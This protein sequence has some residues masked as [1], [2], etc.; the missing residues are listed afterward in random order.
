M[1]PF[2]AVVIR[3]C[4]AVIDRL[5]RSVAVPCMGALMALLSAA[6]LRWWFDARIS[7]TFKGFDAFSPFPSR[8][9]RRT[10][11]FG[12]R[13]SNPERRRISN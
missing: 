5:I 9:Y 4:M 12:S 10:G 2:V 6:C 11:P 3:L 7:V 13:S 8:V 1:T